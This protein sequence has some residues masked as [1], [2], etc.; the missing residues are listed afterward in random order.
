MRPYRR[1][2][3]ER[4]VAGMAAAGLAPTIERRGR[5]AFYR[6]SRDDFRRALGV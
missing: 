4:M 2:T 6:L 1:R 3:I 5:E